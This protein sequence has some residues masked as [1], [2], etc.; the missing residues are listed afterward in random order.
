MRRIAAVG[1]SPKDA[2]LED[3]YNLYLLT[4]RDILQTKSR[5]V[6]DYWMLAIKPENEVIINS[7]DAKRLSIK[8]GDRVK[9]VSATN[10][11]GI[12]LRPNHCCKRMPYNP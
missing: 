1:D 3:G 12:W 11:E 10:I 5:T 2:G 8:D 9:V 7:I 6:V 4:Q